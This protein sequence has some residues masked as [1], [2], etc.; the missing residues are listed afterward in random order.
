MHLSSA[1][2]PAPDRWPQVQA[3]ILLALGPDNDVAGLAC[4]ELLDR[5]DMPA[6]PLEHNDGRS[7]VIRRGA[8]P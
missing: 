8:A 5:L 6:I 4:R 2:E 1:P 7:K 3:L